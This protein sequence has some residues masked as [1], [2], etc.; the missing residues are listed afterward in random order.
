MIEDSVE[1]HESSH[2]S[3]QENNIFSN[4][5][6]QRKTFDTEFIRSNFYPLKFSKSDIKYLSSDFIDQTLGGHR[7]YREELIKGR[8]GKVYE[9]KIKIIKYDSECVNIER[10]PTNETSP[11]VVVENNLILPLN[12]DLMMESTINTSPS[13]IQESA[14]NGIFLQTRRGRPRKYPVGQEPYKKR[15]SP[16][17][18][19]NFIPKVGCYDSGKNTFNFT[20]DIKMD[21]PSSIDQF[22]FRKYYDVFEDLHKNV[23]FDDF[24][25]DNSFNQ[26]EDKKDQIN[27]SLNDE[28]I[29]DWRE[30]FTKEYF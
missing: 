21:S 5:N 19:Q 14:E 8:I 24:K 28:A 20:N 9:Y 18:N 29:N 1:L 22:D 10:I 25:K 23:L 27:S 30:L 13:K 6:K 16:I 3:Q 17:C 2:Q 15:K 4:A 11:I 7:V 26:Q 12:R